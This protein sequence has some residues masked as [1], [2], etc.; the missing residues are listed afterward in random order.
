[1]KTNIALIKKYNIDILLLVS[2]FLWRIN[3]GL[4][5]ESFN[6]DDS[7]EILIYRTDSLY[8]FFAFADHHLLYSLLLYVWL[9]FIS[10]N[11]IQIINIVFCI[12]IVF[13]TKHMYTKF[14]FGYWPFILNIF[15]LFNSPIFMDYSLRIKQYTLD[16]LLILLLI[17]LLLDVQTDSIT[18]NR[19]FLFGVLFST[20][21]LILLPVF[22]V[23]TIFVLHKRVKSFNLP[24]LLIPLILIIFFHFIGIVRLKI[25]D[26]E[27]FNYYSYSFNSGSGI[28]REIQNLFFNFLILVRGISDNGYLALFLLLFLFGLIQI[29]KSKSILLYVFLLVLTIF[30]ILH[31]LDLYPM[32]GGR[33][34]IFIYP[35]VLI[36]FSHNIKITKNKVLVLIL[37]ILNIFTITSF[38]NFNYPDTYIKILIE[39]IGNQD[40][41]IVDYYS[42]PQYTLYQDEVTTKISRR[43]SLEEDCLYS[44]NTESILFLQNNR[45]KSIDIETI[46]LKILEEYET[47]NI[48]SE[49]NTI[50]SIDDFESFFSKGGY[51]LEDKVEYKKS[52]KLVYGRK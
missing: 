37:V 40:L 16:Y 46:E 23:F 14:S 4:F 45:C 6:Y 33:N 18:L 10:I 41:T 5:P 42:I 24:L 12:C 7:H 8:D 11:S 22:S 17:N 35:L 15:V 49:Y 3:T 29:Y 25:F 47:I 9:L 31:L 43:Y 19:F 28:G 34:M 50:N 38:A 32:G 30:S 27:F 13:V 51:V 39:D 20:F 2:F 52:Y 26:P 21:S 36:L 44:S 48:I 1:M